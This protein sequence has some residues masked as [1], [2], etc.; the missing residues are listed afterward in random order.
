MGTGN[1]KVHLD[2]FRMIREGLSFDGAV[3]ACG[4]KYLGYVHV[5]VK[6][7]VYIVQDLYVGESILLL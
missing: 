6:T 7:G 5:F 3:K 2:N 4:R 1:I